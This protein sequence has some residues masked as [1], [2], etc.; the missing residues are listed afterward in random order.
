MPHKNYGEKTLYLKEVCKFSVMACII[1]E[2]CCN[3]AMFT[4]D[5][6]FNVFE[7]ILWTVSIAAIAPYAFYI[8]Y[9]VIRINR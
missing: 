3:Y 2:S 5:Y 7:T 8:H 4:L 9:K 6:T 1:A